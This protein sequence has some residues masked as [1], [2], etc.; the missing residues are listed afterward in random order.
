MGGHEC[1]FKTSYHLKSSNGFKRDSLGAKI[2]I[3]S[4]SN[5]NRLRFGKM[6]IYA[7][8]KQHLKA[9]KDYKALTFQGINEPKANVHANKSANKPVAPSLR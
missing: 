9:G 7:Y 2:N 1:G 5:G 6:L 4:H 8:K 3:L